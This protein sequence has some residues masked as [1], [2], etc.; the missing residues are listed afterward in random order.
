MKYCVVALFDGELIR[1]GPLHLV[2]AVLVSS[3]FLRSGVQ[4]AFQTEVCVR[5]RPENKPFSC[6]VAKYVALRRGYAVKPVAAPGVNI[7]L[8]RGGCMN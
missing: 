8:L 5:H 1:S 4:S 3:H 7:L 6:T 2:D